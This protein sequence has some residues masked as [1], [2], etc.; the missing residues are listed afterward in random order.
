MYALNLGEGGRILSACVV[1]PTG[2]YGGMP[3]AGHLPEGDVSDYRY[4][5]GEYVRDPLPVPEPPE[6]VPTAEEDIQGLVVDHEYRLT[7]LELG[8][9]E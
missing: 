2:S 1:L 3:Q 6:E 8:I 5:G 4:E 7:L 9:T